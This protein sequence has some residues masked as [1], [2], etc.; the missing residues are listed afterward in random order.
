MNKKGIM[1]TLE[2][3]IAIVIL[4][5]II[6]TIIPKRIDFEEEIPINV[7]TSQEFILNTLSDN[8]SLRDCVINNPL[9]KNN[10]DMQ[11]FVED[12]KPLGYNYDFEI[13]NKADCVVNTLPV[14][15]AVYV[16]DVFISEGEE[17]PKIFRIWMWELD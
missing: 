15:K 10:N 7:K 17:S 12:N 5:I 9:C 1:K 16:N 11:R 4:L 8:D 6:F 3:M 14:D 2:A 13:C